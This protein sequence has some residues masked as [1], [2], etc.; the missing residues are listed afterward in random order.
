MGSLEAFYVAV[1]LQGGEEDVQEP[2]QHEEAG[3]EQL[4]SP[5]AP[6]FPPDLWP[7]PVQ[8][9]SHIDEREDGEEGDRE[10]Q[11]AGGH[12]ELFPVGRV[13][14]GGNGPGHTD[15]QEHIDGVAA[16]DIADGGICILV[17]GGCHLAGECIC[18]GRGR[19]VSR[20]VGWGAGWGEGCRG[21]LASQIHSWTRHEPRNPGL[22][23]VPLGTRVPWVGRKLGRFMD[24][25]GVRKAEMALHVSTLLLHAQVKPGL[26][27]IK[28]GTLMTES[29][30]PEREE[31]KY[32]VTGGF[33]H[34]AGFGPPWCVGLCL[35]VLERTQ[36][37]GIQPRPNRLAL[38]PLKV[39][40][41]AAFP[42][43][44]F[45]SF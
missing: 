3:R 8:Q 11:C 19:E 42:S 9:H 13:V 37:A 36:G 45:K 31:G 38:S 21:T 25:V 32:W 2:E 14:N 22:S 27:K 18:E 16:R 17:L 35:A 12:S 5:G 41:F 30:L 1:S 7:A 29:R 15:A 26:G 40:C 20:G 10:G 39:V 34:M 33:V 28:W 44:P 4:G 24:E 43:P 6:Q 23:T